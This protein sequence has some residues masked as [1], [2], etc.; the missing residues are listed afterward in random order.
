MRGEWVWFLAGELK[1]KKK[2]F[3]IDLS[4][5]MTIP[6]TFLL[7]VLLIKNFFVYTFGYFFY[8]FFSYSNNIRLL[9][10][11]LSFHF[12]DFI[13]L[14]HI[15]HSHRNFIWIMPLSKLKVASLN[16]QYEELIFCWLSLM[17]ILMPLLYNNIVYRIV[18]VFSTFPCVKFNIM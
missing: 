4:W 8:F 9:I 17:C 14:F 5:N 1:K 16:Q 3:K 11:W 12:P 2:K 18:P 6:Y 13:I 10:L 7:I 15:I